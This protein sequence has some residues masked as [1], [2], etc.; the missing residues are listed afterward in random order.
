[1]KMHWEKPTNPGGGWLVYS[2]VLNLAVFVYFSNSDLIIGVS[3]AFCFLMGALG[4]V[5]L[6]WPTFVSQ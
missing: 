6:H 2:V 1:M 3:A 5:E 4:E